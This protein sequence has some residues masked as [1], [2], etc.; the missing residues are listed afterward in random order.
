MTNRMKWVALI[1]LLFCAS[2]GSWI[3]KLVAQ[4]MYSGGQAVTITSGTVT[5]QQST[6]SSLKVD[7]SGTN[8]NATALKVDP[9]AVTSPVSLAALPALVAG[10]AKIGITYP[11]TSC[12]TTAFTEALQAMPTSST[13]ITT[14]TT[15]ILQLTVS[16]TS[17][18]ALTVTVSDNQGTPVNFLNA[19]TLNSG[20][21][22]NYPA[23]GKFTSGIKVQ[24]SGTGITYSLEG[25]Q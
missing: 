13:A 14:T 23:I 4:Q 17:G 21:T 2:F 11:Y 16:N 9:S 7:L 22:R 10:T 6:A 12:A 15:C 1:G 25:V 18:G 20:E 5:V 3:G 8:A 24:A 19:V